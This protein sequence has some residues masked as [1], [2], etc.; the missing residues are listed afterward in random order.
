MVARVRFSTAD[1]NG[2]TLPSTAVDFAAAV[3]DCSTV[4]DFTERSA[5]DIYMLYTGGTT[6]YP[7]GVLWRHEDV[8]RTLGVADAADVPMLILCLARPELVER[9]SSSARYVAE[10]T[11]EAIRAVTAPAAG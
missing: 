9:V 1:D 6:G 10:G 7:K 5:D 8:W 4:R 2:A 3:A 11:W